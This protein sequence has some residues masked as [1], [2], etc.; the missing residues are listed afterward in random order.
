ML[1]NATPA[2][3]D[4]A[5][6]SW[7]VYLQPGIGEAYPELNTKLLN[8]FRDKVSEIPWLPAGWYD[9]VA[10]IQANF[11]GSQVR[12]APALLVSGGVNK[13]APDWLDSD[14]K[15]QYWQEL[16]VQSNSIVQKYAAGKAE[17]GRAELD[18]LYANAAFWDRAY[19]IAVAIRDAPANAVKAAGEVVTG[20]AWEGLKGFIIPA[21]IVAVVFIL[22]TG[23]DSFAKAAVKKATGG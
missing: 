4:A 16:N 11:P 8:F 2:E 10:G 20:I 22:W 23:R 21:A 17:E 13:L 19:N 5:W 7:G 12:I 18:Q 6:K 1:N 15:R 9:A 3:S 14:E